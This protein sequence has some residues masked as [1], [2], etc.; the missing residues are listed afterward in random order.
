MLEE[1]GEPIPRRHLLRDLLALLLPHH[2]SLSSFNRGMKFLTRFAVGTRYPGEDATK[3][4]AAAALRWAD[5]LRTAAR[6][7]L[8]LPLGKKPKRKPSK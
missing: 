8:G 3:R 4:Q 5:Q 1:L 2:P 7:V 6:T